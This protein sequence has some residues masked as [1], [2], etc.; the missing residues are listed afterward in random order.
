MT[1][2]IAGWNVGTSTVVSWKSRDGTVI[3]GVLHKPADFDPAK[4]YPLLVVIHGG[5]TG[6]DMPG[7][8]RVLRSIRSGVRGE[9]RPGA[10]SQLPGLGGLRREVPVAERP[11]PGRGRLL[12]RDVGG[13][14]L[15]ATGLRGQDRMG[16]MGWSQGGYISAFLT[17]IQRPVQ[18]DLGGGG[19]LQ[20]DD[21]LRHD[22]HHPF[23]RQYL[24]GHA[25]GAIRRSTEDF[26]DDATST[27]AKTPTLIQHGEFDRRVPLPNG[28]ELNQGLQ[29]H[30][31]PTKMMVYR[32]SVTGSQAEGAAGGRVA[33]LA[34]V[35]E[36]H[37]RRAGNDSAGGAGREAGLLSGH[38]PSTWVR[39]SSGR[40]R[41]LGVGV[42]HPGA[43]VPA[44]KGVV[45]AGRPDRLGLL[46]AL[47]R[48]AN[49]S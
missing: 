31:V 24:Q 49:Q 21:V 14:S 18:G 9:G 6:V 40:G 36:V 15:I 13:G 19:N 47:H 43:G 44:E 42:E 30:G 28:Y 41:E 39:G 16:A 26:A 11:E 4:K 12:G 2:Q 33:Q 27:K 32:A 5:P 3:E 46:V 38:S 8:V 7:P 1:S 45:V 10:A 37:F 23:T 35:R 17:T 48:L 22:R 34:V 20:L 25:V 29:D